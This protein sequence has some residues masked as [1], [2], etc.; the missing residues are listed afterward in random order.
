MFDYFLILPSLPVS[1][2]CHK[3]GNENNLDRISH[4]SHTENHG[5]QSC[6]RCCT[7]Y[8][9]W[10]VRTHF[11]F[12]YHYL[13]DLKIE[14]DFYFYF[15]FYLNF[16]MVIFVN[17]DCFSITILHFLF[18]ISIYFFFPDIYFLFIQLDSCGQYV[19]V[20]VLTEPF[21]PRC[22]SCTTQVSLI[23][24]LIIILILICV[25]LPR[26]QFD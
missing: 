3:T 4:K 24:I 8:Q 14:I 7:C 21:G 9:R 22:T 12:N 11:N 6:C 13:T 19:H 10:H 23:Y 17:N 1:C 20:P 18:T 25:L 5:Y 16:F 15:H 26:V 2:R